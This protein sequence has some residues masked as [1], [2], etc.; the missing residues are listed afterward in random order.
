MSM[1][2]KLHTLKIQLISSTARAILIKFTIANRTA[3]YILWLVFFVFSQVL[4]MNLFSDFIMRTKGFA[5]GFEKVTVRGWITK[6]QT[7]IASKGSSNSAV[8]SSSYLKSLHASS[9]L[10]ARVEQTTFIIS[11]LLNSSRIWPLGRSCWHFGFMTGFTSPHAQRE[12]GFAFRNP[13]KS[14]ITL[15]H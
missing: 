9:F 4:S 5:S 10:W 14:S 1:F 7:L 2:W 8:F 6:I 12:H 3:H 13:K 15:F 11:F